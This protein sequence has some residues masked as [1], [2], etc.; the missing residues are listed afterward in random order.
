MADGAPSAAGADVELEDLPAD[1]LAELL[2]DPLEDPD[3]LAADGP[4]LEEADR[5]DPVRLAATARGAAPAPSASATACS[6]PNSRLACV[7]GVS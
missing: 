2:E 6:G 4:E 3:P 7:A 5:E 1:P